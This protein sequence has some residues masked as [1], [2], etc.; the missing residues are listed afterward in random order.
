M[1]RNKIKL[2]GLLIVLLTAGCGDSGGAA[3]DGSANG[4]GSP[5]GPG[6][7]AA[8]AAPDGQKVYNRACFSCHAAGIAG[9]PKTGDAE[10]WA[11]RVAQGRDLLL[12][13]TING[14]VPG[15][16]PRGACVGC[17]DEE[18]GAALDFMLDKLPQ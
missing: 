3:P 17:S 12:Q 5:G 14:I 11:P 15:M 8:A 13:A 2:A 16:P 9:A 1:L 10:A 7:T 18:L 4:A 6:A